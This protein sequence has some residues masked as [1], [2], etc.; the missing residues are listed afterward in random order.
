MFFRGLNKKKIK[1]KG[2]SN[3]PAFM[4][5]SKEPKMNLTFNTMNTRPTTATTTGIRSKK[6]NVNEMKTHIQNNINPEILRPYRISSAQYKIHGDD[7]NTK[8]RHS[9]SMQ[10]KKCRPKSSYAANNQFTE[11]KSDHWNISTDGNL[12]KPS[13]DVVRQLQRDQL[14]I[15]QQ[16]KDITMD[17]IEK[18]SSI[19]LAIENES[20]KKIIKSAVN[21]QMNLDDICHDGNYNYNYDLSNSK[22]MK[23]KKTESAKNFISNT[24]QDNEIRKSKSEIKEIVYDDDKIKR[25]VIKLQSFWRMCIQREKHR[26]R[27][28]R[29]KEG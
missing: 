5:K 7:N 2:L 13:S 3:S 6:T 15:D 29:K 23:K 21:S 19:N 17:V 20:Y 24:S 12:R 10:I 25:I 26:L 11:V 18:K 8:H 28:M 1:I 22:R 9:K 16:S 14:D 4:Q 27:M